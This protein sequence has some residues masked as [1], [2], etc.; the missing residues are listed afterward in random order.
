MTFAAPVKPK[1]EDSSELGSFKYPFSSGGP[2]PQEHAMVT[3]P[4]QAAERSFIGRE[5]GDLVHATISRHPLATLDE[6]S[7]FREEE[8]E[9]PE[10]HGHGRGA[11]NDYPLD[12]Y[13]SN[14]YP[15][16]N[17]PSGNY[18]YNNYPPNNFSQPSYGPP[19]PSLAQ[20]ISNGASSKRIS[21][22]E[23]SLSSGFGE[24]SL[25]PPMPSP[26]NSLY[27][28]PLD[29]RRSRIRDTWKLSRLSSAPSNAPHTPP[30]SL[31]ESLATS[32]GTPRESVARFRSVHGWVD[33]QSSRADTSSAR[34]EFDVPVQGRNEER[35]MDS[36]ID[37]RT[38]GSTSTPFGLQ[39]AREEQRDDAAR[40]SWVTE[41]NPAS[42]NE[43]IFAPDLDKV[44]AMPQGRATYT[45]DSA[46]TDT[47][48]H[49][50]S[51]EDFDFGYPTSAVDS[52]PVPPL[53]PLSSRPGERRQHD[54]DDIRRMDSTSTATVFRF[55]PGEEVR[56]GHHRLASEELDQ[57][58][59][60]G[61]SSRNI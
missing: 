54:P 56:L 46:R 28:R 31:R 59:R 53:P 40:Q 60:R 51:G 18:D 10:E 26:E 23:S 13:S 19:R 25:P 43:D 6:H 16:Q 15:P 5:R 17:N 11:P 35:G 21:P 37:N 47:M 34:E 58:F 41:C 57:N 24:A 14:N 39:A 61:P 4:L 3:P 50:Y 9:G 33:Y 20:Q 22:G 38:S 12:N 32:L 52:S 30:S 8:E 49:Y 1:E 2:N 7:F 27:V 48:L 44:K 29:T 45:R 42:D 55:H 36:R